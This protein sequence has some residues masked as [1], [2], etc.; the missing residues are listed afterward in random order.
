VNDSTLL[1]LGSADVDQALTEVDP[2]ACVHEALTLHAAGGALRWRPG[3]GEAARSLNMPGLLMG[4]LQ[5]AGTKIVNANPSNVQR[6]L[7]RA[8]ALILLFDFHTA[9][10]TCAMQGTHIS[11]LRTA[12]V[13]FLA[14][15]RLGPAAGRRLAVIG[16]GPIGAT[17]ARLFARRLPGLEGVVLADADP[18]RAKALH[19]ELFAE[20]E[21]AG[22]QLSLAD[23]VPAALD[24][25]A[26]VVTATTVN[27]PY[28]AYEQLAPGM[29]LVNV[30][31][32][33]FDR[34]VVLK[35]G[36]VYVDDWSLILA[37]RHRLLGRLA[38]EGLVSGPGEPTPPGGRAV[39]G[40][41]G[42][43]LNGQIAGRTNESEIILVNPFGLAIEDLAIALRVHA[44]ARQRGL[45]TSLPF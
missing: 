30:S 37:D 19:Q 9:R 25:A 45:G 26:V 32:D 27:E 38:R 4:E 43:L 35:A 12:A 42:Q 21:V 2:V 15:Q 23:S 6:G 16:C 34:G 14:A 3:D 41:L 39:D 1:F 13:S 33:D 44:V 18:A 20:L 24:G 22:V 28:I 29:L 10:V 7:P 11:A 31:L 5:A 8:S 36:R 40:T 17:H